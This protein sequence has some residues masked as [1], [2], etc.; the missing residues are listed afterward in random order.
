MGALDV[1]PTCRLVHTSTELRYVQ[2]AAD[3]AILRIVH[4]I[5]AATDPQDQR[6]V[7]HFQLKL[8]AIE[9]QSGLKKDGHTK[10]FIL[11][12]YKARLAT[13]IRR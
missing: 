6:S 13:G 5:R 9:C 4:L 2:I 7:S 1:S 11:Q 3:R 10:Q 12:D 8:P